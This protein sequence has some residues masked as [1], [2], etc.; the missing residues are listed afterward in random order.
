MDRDLISWLF[1][2]FE[3]NVY[4]NYFLIMSIILFIVFFVMIFVILYLGVTYNEG[5]R[6]YII[7]TISI[8]Q[9][10]LSYFVMRLL[11]SMCVHSM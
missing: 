6:Y 3:K 1:A 10:G 2:P 5:L 11:Y 8:L 7:N 9:V 4:C